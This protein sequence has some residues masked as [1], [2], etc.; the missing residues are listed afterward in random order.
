MALQM[1]VNA[2][3]TVNACWC[4]VQWGICLCH[5]QPCFTW[6]PLFKAFSASPFHAGMYLLCVPLCLQ[7]L[8]NLPWLKLT[9]N[10]VI[11]HICVCPG[12][13]DTHGPMVSLPSCTKCLKN[14]AL[15]ETCMHAYNPLLSTAE[16]RL[17]PRASHLFCSCCPILLSRQQLG[18]VV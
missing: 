15:P 4:Y 18:S 11:F 12:D 5:P 9:T 1:P 3:G 17:L 14:N 2:D 13:H 10:H 8:S 16:H 6:V 7:E